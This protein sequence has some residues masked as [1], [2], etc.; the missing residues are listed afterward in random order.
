MRSRELPRLFAVPDVPR[1]PEAPE[2][3][4]LLGDAGDALPALRL[5]HAGAVRVA[6]L[7]PPYNR[8]TR[9]HH[10]EDALAHDLWL[11]ERRE[12]LAV[13]RDLLSA[14]GSLWL[15][16][17]DAEMHYCKVMLDTLFGRANFVATIV[18]QK[19]RS[20]ENRTA[21]STAHEYLLVYAKDRR[22]WNA[23]RNLVPLGP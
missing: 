3:H 21:I 15:H 10:Y 14:D 22:A 6:L 7:D 23:R 19:T 8:S 5:D 4:L 9:F 12:H 2:N 18:W 1:A 17:D 20:R 11:S 13:A 16:L